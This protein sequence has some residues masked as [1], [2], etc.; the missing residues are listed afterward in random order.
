MGKD[1]H[2]GFELLNQV[3]KSTAVVDIGRITV[4]SGNE[5]YNKA[6]VTISLGYKFL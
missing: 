6:K 4:P 5:T 1:N 3:L 2:I